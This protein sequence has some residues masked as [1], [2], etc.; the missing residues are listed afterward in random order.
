M[1]TKRFTILCKV[2]VHKAY[3]REY[4]MTGWQGC[5]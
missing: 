4:A 2:G 3:K 1:P 5:L